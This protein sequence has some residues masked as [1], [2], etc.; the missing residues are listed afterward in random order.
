MTNYDSE[1]RIE[2]LIADNNDLFLSVAVA[3]EQFSCLRL[4]EDSISS[5]ML[6][7]HRTVLT[8]PSNWCGG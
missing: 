7:C 5:N 8:G 6:Q 3:T 4:T 1:L 2:V